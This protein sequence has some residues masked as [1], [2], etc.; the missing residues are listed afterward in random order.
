MSLRKIL[1]YFAIFSIFVYFTIWISQTSSQLSSSN[2][3]GSSKSN[4]KGKIVEGWPPDKDRNVANYVK[5]GENN[6]L[7]QPSFSHFSNCDLLIVIHSTIENFSSRQ[8]LRDTW[9]KFISEEKV[10]NVS[11]VFL[12]GSQ[13]IHLNVT[14]ST[15]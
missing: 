8:A 11:Y 13:N 9:I 12:V 7:I 1:K 3:S 15:L 10:Q 5:P 4:Y 6:F 14:N 2:S